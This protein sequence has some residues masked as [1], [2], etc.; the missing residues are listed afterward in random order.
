MVF[1]KRDIPASNS[2]V[3][4]E[5]T[6]V[7]KDKLLQVTNQV[8]MA[9]MMSQFTLLM[10]YSHEVFAGLLDEANATFGR[11]KDLGDRV[12][13]LHEGL[14]SIEAMFDG[15][16]MTVLSRMNSTGA[17]RYLAANPERQDLFGAASMPAAVKAVRGS[18]FAPPALHL[19]DPFRSG[20]D[21]ASTLSRY[22]NP[23]FF[24]EQWAAEQQAK[25]DELRAERKKKRAERVARR[26]ERDAQTVAAK[27][28]QKMKKIRYDPQ[29]GERIVEEDDGSSSA[30]LTARTMQPVGGQSSQASQ[31]H[32][33]ASQTPRE[34]PAVPPKPSSVHHT[35]SHPTNT[36]PAVPANLPPPVSAATLPPPVSAPAP[37]DTATPREH[38]KDKKD[39]KEKEK[40]KSKDKKHRPKE[41]APLPPP[42][43]VVA[44]PP[45][46]T[47]APQPISNHNHP[48]VPAPMPPT[49]DA[50]LPPA[51]PP[52][53]APDAPLPPSMAPVAP[54]TFAQDAPPAPPVAPP[55]AP[56]APMMGGGPAPPP[57][58]P[59]PAASSGG[60]NDLM[61]AIRGGSN[62]KKA[63]PGAPSGAA[64]EKPV[65]QRSNLMENIRLG[66]K[67]KSAGDR[68]IEVVKDQ[69]AP[70]SVA[71]ILARRIA[72]EPDSDDDVDDDN[73]DW[74]D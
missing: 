59:P 66:L 73:D 20:E 4:W 56:P 21:R 35:P 31:T 16:D 27:P 62:L 3:P 70:S 38:K 74:S 2:L 43:S 41:D 17:S 29:T 12:S 25:T 11:L 15:D 26:A 58:P 5:A 42:A 64:I 24:L 46:N 19:L 18:C 60:G 47:V 50:P 49:G 10:T 52:T 13:A 63:E 55:V 36:A 69:G 40:E 51:L 68:K 44:P 8:N 39:K 32:Q 65:D 71:E 14:P 61:A 67:L 53:I 23:N 6:E 34:V 54:P 9:G 45:P 30:P 22:S 72:I 33:T 1:V 37:V 28:V 7:P 57:P 48:D